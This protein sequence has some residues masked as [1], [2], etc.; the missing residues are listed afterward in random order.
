MK[1]TIIKLNKNEYISIFLVLV[2]TRSTPYDFFFFLNKTLP[3]FQ[4]K[5]LCTPIFKDSALDFSVSTYI[6]GIAH[7][8]YIMVTV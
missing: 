1:V 8:V 6:S 4:S 2:F 7:V 5:L 3:F